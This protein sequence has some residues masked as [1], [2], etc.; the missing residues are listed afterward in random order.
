[1][2]LQMHHPTITRMAEVM[3]ERAAITGHCTKSDLHCAGFDDADI[4]KYEQAAAKLAAKL[5]G[6]S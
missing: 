3:R 1:M 5:E 4:A 2:E 6:R